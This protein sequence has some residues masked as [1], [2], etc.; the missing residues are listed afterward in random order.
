M[1]RNTVAHPRGARPV[2]IAVTACAALLAGTGPLAPGVASAA[3][4]VPQETVVP[5]ALRSTYTSASFYAA[6]TLT[7]ADGAGSQGFFHRLEGYSGLVWSRYGG[8]APVPVPK[9]E[10]SYF[11]EPTGSDVLAYCYPDRVELWDASDGTTRT[12]HVPEGQSV[13]SVYGTTVVTFRNSTTANGT[14]TRVMHLLTSGPDGTTRDVPVVGAPEDMVL[15]QPHGADAAG[16]L[17]QSQQ[18]DGTVRMVVVDRETGRVQGW[19]QRLPSGYYRAKISPDHIVVYSSSASTVLVLPRSDVSATP[20]EVALD[21]GFS[22]PGHELALAGD[23]LVYRPG[24]VATL[25]AMPV[26]GGQPITVVTGSNTGL[27][28]APDG[29]ALAIGRTS[30]TLDDRGIQHIRPG[31]DT[32]PVVTTVRPLPRPVV[33]VEGL[34]LSQ[35]RLVDAETGNDRRT[36]YV[37]NVA[38]TGTPE[39][40][41]HTRLTPTSDVVMDDCPVA[42]PGCA[43]VFDVGD[44]RIAWI[45]RQSGGSDLLRVHGPGTYDLYQ[46]RVPAGGRIT[47]VSG[48]YLIHTTAD[49]QSVYRLDDD[50]APLTRAPSAAA[51]WENRLWTPAATPGSVS[52]LDLVSKKTVQTVGTGASCVP[53]ELQAVGRW[54]Y[55]SCGADG[56][57]GVYDRTNKTSVA[58]PSGE[59][60]LGDGYVVTHDRQAGK[61]NLTTVGSGSPSTRVIG[62]LPDTGTSQRHVRWTVDRYSGNVAY[63]DAQERIHLVPSGVTTTQSLIT[64]RE[65]VATSV[66]AEWSA[67]RTGMRGTAVFDGV[68]S[69]PVASWTLVVRD[70]NTNRVVDR[71]QGGDTR[72]RLDVQWTGMDPAKHYETPLPNGRYT[73]ELTANPA[74]G[75]GAALRRQG[76]VRLLRGQPVPRDHAGSGA[77]PDAIADLLTLDSHGTLTFH[78]GNGAGKFSGKTSGRGWPTSVVAVPFGDLNKDKCND[79]L[80]RMA[81]GSLRAYRPACGKPLTPST[82]YRT[83]SGGTGW[84]AYDVLTAPGDLTGDGLTDL[85][86]RKASTGAMYLFAAKPDGTLAAGKKIAS[87]WGSYTKIIGV[88][89]LNGD[90]LGDV[91]ARHKNGT[92]YRYYGTKGGLSTKRVKLFSKW[93]ASYN[94]VVGVGDITSDGKPDLVARDTS[95]NLW[96]Q[97]GDGR[98]S[99]GARTKIATGWKGYKGL[100]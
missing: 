7:G 4:A 62:E 29:T 48:G 74:D 80:V 17:F 36:P 99:F 26:A 84:K 67:N 16:V 51:V 10:G 52:A 66:N 87:G 83:L 71:R 6:N 18:R 61:L 58:V 22:K 5:A 98:G 3:P 25:K 77:S 92:L 65:E 32:A 24:A 21:S 95:G 57:A 31:D 70:K 69:K 81:N 12:V 50:G 40:G 30:A 56:P 49:K 88:G 41:E 44:G 37:R 78:H 64:L 23:W 54:L 63:V 82:P 2:G 100:F 55:W 96:L 75:R 14:S 89:D 47:D 11:T 1:F 35:G 28:S 9:A 91:L 97:K 20:V 15:G 72:G 34:V 46:R 39:F 43:S 59:A 33:P 19:T 13:L 38:V 45:E 86:A 8:G 60:L 53:Q 85:L 42:D 27:V 79:V 73:W 90:G 76:T 94:A 68:F 93:G